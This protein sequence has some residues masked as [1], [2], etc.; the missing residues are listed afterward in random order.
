MKIDLGTKSSGPGCCAPSPCC[1]G[2][3]K[4][5]YP[6]LYLSGDKKI[7]LPDSGSAVI[8][9]RKVSSGEDQREGQDAH[10]RCEL[11]IHSIEVKSA[12]RKDDGLVDVG[13]ALKDAMRRKMKEKLE[14][15]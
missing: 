12:D 6:S 14:G 4:T 9:F 1:E 11:E 13:S 5:Y 3:E 10:Y 2:E 8:T 15:E 7:S